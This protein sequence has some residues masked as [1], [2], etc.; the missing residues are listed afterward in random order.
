MALPLAHGGAV[1]LA[2]AFALL[3]LGLCALV[4]LGIL[5]VAAM[6]EDE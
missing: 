2:L 1:I 3:Y 6:L 4:G 5:A